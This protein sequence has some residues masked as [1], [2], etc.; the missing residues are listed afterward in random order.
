[1][2]HHVIKHNILQTR[3]GL[4]ITHIQGALQFAGG[5]KNQVTKPDSSVEYLI[6]GD[7]EYHKR[8][9][10]H[11]EECQVSGVTDDLEQQSSMEL[12]VTGDQENH[13]EQDVRNAKDAGKDEKQLEGKY[14]LQASK[15]SNT[16]QNKR[17]KCFAKHFSPKFLKK[18]VTKQPKSFYQE[19]RRSMSK[20]IKEA[21]TDFYRQEEN[22]VFLPDMK[23]V[24][25]KN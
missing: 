8:E 22:V 16:R 14:K 12:H 19:S 17:R 7:T 21:A 18:V 15:N 10:E 23:Y 5:I 13:E 1:M 6:P 4:Q 20:E 3:R 11:S 25:K 9:L 24:S 2:N